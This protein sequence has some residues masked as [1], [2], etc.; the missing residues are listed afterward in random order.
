MVTFQPDPEWFKGPYAHLWKP[1]ADK[2][3][4]L[5][6]E[7]I[8]R[9][10]DLEDS[11][12]IGLGADSSELIKIP[13]HQK[14]EPDMDVY[15]DYQLLCHIEVSGTD[16]KNVRVP[17]DNIW[18]RPGKIALGVEKE[19]QGE[20]YWFY[21]VYPNS[22]CVL[23][24]TDAEPYRT[25]TLTVSPYGK[26]EVFSEIPHSVAQPKETLFKWIEEQI[27]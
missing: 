23:R 10:P 6:D 20:P 16:S 24:A 26:R 3:K 18:I 11:I 5:Y 7:L 19:K 17:P 13:P 14:D 27:S 21:M 2:V 22:V 25:N 1:H 4:A 8:E 9:F 12:R 15:H